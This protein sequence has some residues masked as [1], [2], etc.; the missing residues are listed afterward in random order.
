MF[1][2]E[3]SRKDLFLQT[4]SLILNNSLRLEEISGSAVGIGIDNLLTT[5]DDS[6]ANDPKGESDRASAIRVAP[7]ET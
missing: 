3:H 4:E 6:D 5:I 7:Q 1:L 2:N